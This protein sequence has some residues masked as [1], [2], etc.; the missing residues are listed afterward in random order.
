MLRHIGTCRLIFVCLLIIRA[1]TSAL[2][3]AFELFHAK[4]DQQAGTLDFL[5][6]PRAASNACVI[7]AY[8]FNSSIDQ[9]LF[10]EDRESRVAL[11]RRN[12][13]VSAVTKE[14]FDSVW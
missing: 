3:F 2:S 5:P 1:T 9:I 12:G 13:M 7:L 6:V 10:N 14:E 11:L 4:V 8:H